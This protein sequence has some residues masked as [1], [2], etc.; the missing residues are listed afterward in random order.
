MPNLAG[1]WPIQY[2]GGGAALVPWQDHFENQATSIANALDDYQ[3]PL[4]VANQAGRDALFPSPA[5]GDRVWRRDLAHEQYYNGTAWVSPGQAL[6]E[7]V[8]KVTQS[9]SV[10]AGDQVTFSVTFPTSRFTVAPRV[11]CQVGNSRFISA[12][13]SITSSGFTY[14]MT[15]VSSGASGGSF[16]NFWHAIQMTDSAADG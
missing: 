6:Y 8:G 3:L 14:S 10:A 2:P 13:T 5:T 9:G 11:F 7:A 16:D 4:S 1:R 15:N 12:P